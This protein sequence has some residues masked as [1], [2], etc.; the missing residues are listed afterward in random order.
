[1]ADKLRIAALLAKLVRQDLTPEEGEDLD[2]WRN[3]STDNETLVQEVL[4]DESL[5]EDIDIM[6]EMDSDALQQKIDAGLEAPVPESAPPAQAPIQVSAPVTP[7]APVPIP[8]IRRWMPYIAAAAIITCV[9]L[10]WQI[11]TRHTS[12]SLSQHQPDFFYLKKAPDSGQVSLALADGSII[13][14]DTV[15]NGWENKQGSVQAAIKPQE[16]LLAYTKVTGQTPLHPAYNT[17]T[18]PY[19]NRYRLKL[20]D[21]TEVTMDVGASLRYPIAFTGNK[22]MVELSGK[23]YFNIAPDTQHPFIVRTKRQETEVLGTSFDVEDYVDG[24]Q[25]KVLVDT[26]RVEVHSPKNTT[27]LSPAQQASIDEKGTIKIDTSIDLSEELSWKE[28]YFNFD[29]LD[30]KAAL[31]QLARSYRMQ[32][33]FED[34]IKSGSLGQGNIQRDLPL[35]TLLKDLE[36]PDL[37]FE[38]RMQDSTIVVKR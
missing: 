4:Q 3:L 31:L 23:A 29:K 26:G 6:M 25:A 37:H 27:V 7:P 13:Y 8:M 20:S 12:T 17:L 16:R 33:L 30:I 15:E 11:K 35:K 1:M 9:I 21:G 5:M 2:A 36:L 38:I 10:V 24:S 32:I 19:G 34:N 14:L 18:V 22:R 28:D